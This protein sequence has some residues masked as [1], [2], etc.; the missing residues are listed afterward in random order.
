M[1]ANLRDDV[2]PLLCTGLEDLRNF[3][4][5]TSVKWCNLCLL[6]M[7]FKDRSVRSFEPSDPSKFG[8]R[9]LFDNLG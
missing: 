1:A 2:S 8:F 6:I 4:F 9:Q 7:P 5:N 3:F